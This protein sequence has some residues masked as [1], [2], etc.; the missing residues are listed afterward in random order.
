VKKPVQ[1]FRLVSVLPC[2]ASVIIGCGGFGAPDIDSISKN[3]VGID[4]I[5]LIRPDYSGI[6][7]PPNIGPLNFV[8]ADSGTQ[9]CVVISSANGA[10]IKVVSRNPK[11][12]IPLKQWARLL[13]RNRGERLTFDIF[14]K[15]RE[16]KWF[17]YR[18][19]ENAIAPEKIDPYLFFRTIS[20][21][22]NFSRDICIYQ[23]N[24]ETNKESE[25]IN[26]LNF[27]PGCCNCHTMLNNDPDKMFLHIRTQDFGNSALLVADGK[28]RKINAKFQ[29]T[30]WHPSGRLIAYSINKV[31]Q[32][33]HM[34]WKDIRDVFDH[35]SGIL[36]Y[37]IEKQRVVSV[38]ALFQER[39]L[40]TWPCWSPDGRF[41]YFCSGPVLWDD[42]KVNPPPNVEK[43]C[44]SL[45]RISYDQANDAWGGIDTVLSAHTTGLSISEPRV[46]PDGRFIL[47]CMHQYGQSPYAQMS[48]D[49]YIMDCAT[50]R[51]APLQG[52]NSGFSESWHSWST[53]SR[54]IAFTSKREGGILA[55]IYLSYIDSTG[56]S[57]K[58]FVLP[59][60]DPAFYDS[61][62]KVHNVPE[63]A[64]SAVRV[65]QKALVRAI[66]AGE[67]IDVTIPV[68][69]ATPKAR[70]EGAEPWLP[71][72]PRQ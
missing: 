11:V 13:L 54:W 21:L 32:C 35:T 27:F 41:L 4:R 14:I 49:L 57:R 34:T 68:S 63:L 19:I 38:P 56:T 12:I 65:S 47:F 50:K 8:I 62:I 22:Y 58:S 72:G 55:R 53:N 67:K 40:E 9:Y 16:G 17:K 66:R 20:V 64:T 28:I 71:E 10:P 59:Q 37:N 30:S 6:V 7:V 29:Y 25:V 1:T 51:Y 44:Y 69:T 26:A 23:K 45:L 15:N 48:S 60:N 43:V 36:I 5:P 61:F 31:D 39:V 70:Q 3:S 52:V 33:F 46:S 18:A 24:L 42:F 2:V